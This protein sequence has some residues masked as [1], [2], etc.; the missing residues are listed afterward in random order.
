[1]APPR[2]L[3]F[4]HLDGSGHL[5]PELGDEVIAEDGIGKITSVGSH[6]EMGPIALAVI[7]RN[8]SMEQVS[9]KL[10]SGA[11]VSAAVEEIVPS[12]AGGVVD[13]GDFRKKR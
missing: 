4:L 5:V 13:L 7:K 11:M 6:Y 9:V 3:V 2:R 1:G 10:S 12:N 8:S